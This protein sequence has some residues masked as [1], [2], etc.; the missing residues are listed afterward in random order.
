MQIQ[1][2]RPVIEVTEA[3]EIAERLYGLTGQVTELES[4]RDR[5][6]LIHVDSGRDCILKIA[7]INE[8]RIQ[9]EF[10]NLD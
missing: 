7:N 4:E 6:F 5:N 8:D 3:V 9:L 1:S 10:L 2:Q